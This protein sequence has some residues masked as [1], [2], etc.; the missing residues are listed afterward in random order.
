MFSSVGIATS[1]G[2]GS[3]PDCLSPTASRPTVAS[4]QPLHRMEL[5]A[6]LDPRELPAN[7][8]HPE[9]DAMKSYGEWQ[10]VSGQLHAPAALLPEK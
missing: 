6:Q 3:C 7:W 5:G 9:L 10:E 8:V 2:R 1:F 4:A